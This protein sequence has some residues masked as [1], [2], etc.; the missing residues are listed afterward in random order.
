MKY[1]VLMSA[2]TVESQ[3]FPEQKSKITNFVQD[4]PVAPYM[5]ALAIG[6]FSSRKIAQYQKCTDRVPYL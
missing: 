6:I 4:K 3:M 5:I 1:K 2:N